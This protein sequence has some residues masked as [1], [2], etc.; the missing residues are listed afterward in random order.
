MQSGTL[1][2]NYGKFGGAR[3]IFSKDTGLRITYIGCNVPVD[4]MPSLGNKL[5][6]G[7][8]ILFDESKQNGGDIHY[9]FGLYE[10]AEASATS[11]KVIKIMNNTVAKVGMVIGKAPSTITGTTTGVTIT[12]VDDSNEEYDTLTLSATLGALT[13]SDVL[14]EVTAT[15]ANAKVKV[16]PNALLPYDIDTVAGATMYPLSGVWA[17]LDGVV[18]ERRIPALATIIKKAMKDN[19]T[20]PCLFRF[21]QSKV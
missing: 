10:A 9:S 3:H 5:P 17:V 14:M 1:A 7:T 20:Y 4:R 16:I 19:E 21:T 15:G 8:A 13:V 11:I 18:Y 12:A 2:S 6:A